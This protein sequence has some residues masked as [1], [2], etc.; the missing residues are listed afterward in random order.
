MKVLVTGA[1]GFIGSHLS[2]YLV[3]VMNYDV[4][5]FCYYNQ[6]NSHGLLDNSM[7]ANDI[8]FEMGDIRDYNSIKNAIS[9]CDKVFHLAALNGIPYSYKN[10]LSY[11][12]TNTEGTVNVL[13]ACKELDVP[14]IIT[15]TSEVYGSMQY[16]PMSET[17]P[18]H[19]QSPYAASKSAAD[20]YALSYHLSYKMPI[21]VV[22]PFNNYGPRQS[23]RAIIPSIIVQLLSG[24]KVKV[25]NLHT[26]R[27]FVYVKDTAKAFTELSL[28]S[29]DRWNASPINV[30]TGKS[31]S[32][33]SL[34]CMISDYLNIN[35]L[36][37]KTD[38]DR[39]R[40]SGS[41]VED[42]CGDSMLL[43]NIIKW[44]P[45]SIKDGLCETV[46]WVKNNINLFKNSD[47]YV[48]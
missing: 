26:T 40:P 27:D 44:N 15:S 30:S 24:N 33:K 6:F 14:V 25:G 7:H 22:R 32:I 18:I 43:H 3:D 41:E 28:I 39:V 34:I 5:S 16:N 36:E 47:K 13:E 2:E 35:D 1:D 4:K 21:M 17:H 46:E 42:L 10:P 8:E 9:G 23:M 19:P 45:R 31:Y 37:I 12:K 48:L 20:M 29:N 11:F 38:P